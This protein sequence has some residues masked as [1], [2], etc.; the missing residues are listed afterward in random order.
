MGNMSSISAEKVGED[1]VTMC[2]S[3]HLKLVIRQL[4]KFLSSDLGESRRALCRRATCC[5][6]VAGECAKQEHG[7]LLRMTTKN[8]LACYNNRTLVLGSIL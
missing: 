6:V 3:S 8:V 1:L 4:D 5:N 2:M 7:Q